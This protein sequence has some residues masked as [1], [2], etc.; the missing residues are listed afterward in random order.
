MTEDNTEWDRIA[1]LPGVHLRRTTS[2]TSSK[3][4]GS[5]GEVLLTRRGTT[6]TLADGQV[7]RVDK[8]YPD[9]WRVA[10]SSTGDPLLW[11][12]N[13]HYDRKPTGYVIFPGQ[14][15]SED[16][17]ERNRD[18]MF[19]VKGSR[20]GNAV[21]TAVVP[22]SGTTILWFRQRAMRE[23]EVVVTPEWDLTP[24]VLGT[25][26]LTVAWLSGYFDVRRRA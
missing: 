9:R 2:L 13:R 21:M 8:R 1:S 10:D 18:L 7:L 20:R 23:H 6:M 5:S 24:T 17:S 11:I 26:E 25:I 3:I 22:A 19:P 16:F 14:A 4:T 12:C 15:N